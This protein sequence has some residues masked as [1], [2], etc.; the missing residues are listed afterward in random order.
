MWDIC[1]I[2]AVG[3][4]RLHKGIG[5]G[6]G[7]GV[8]GEVVL[9]LPLVLIAQRPH[10]VVRS[11]RL[12]RP[13]ARQEEHETSDGII[14]RTRQV[15]LSAFCAQPRRDGD[16]VIVGVRQIALPRHVRRDIRRGEVVTWIVGL[17]VGGVEQADDVGAGV[18]AIGGEGTDVEVGEVGEGE[19]AI[20]ALEVVVAVRPSRIGEAQGHDLE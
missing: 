9:L 14:S 17:E 20:D 11:W 18:G 5:A 6:G 2:S 13:I 8:D 19:G 10:V 7:Y 4:A 3:R 16:Q 15:I 12:R 1:H